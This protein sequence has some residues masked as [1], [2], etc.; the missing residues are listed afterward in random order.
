MTRIFT[1]TKALLA[2][3]LF[4][5]AGIVGANAQTTVV[6][7]FTKADAASAFGATVATGSSGYLTVNQAYHHSSDPIAF[8]PTDAEGVRFFCSNANLYT[9][10]VNNGGAFTVS[11]DKGYLITRIRAYISKY[12]KAYLWGDDLFPSNSWGGSETSVLLSNTSGVTC[13]IDS[14]AITY[15]PESTSGK[16]AAKLDFST[17]TVSVIFGETETFTEPTLTG[18]SDGAVSYASSDESVATVDENGNVTIL[19]VGTTEITATS[20]ETDDYDAGTASYTLTVWPLY[21]S[22]S[23]LKAQIVSDASS[24]AKDYY[25]KLT[26]AVV[27]YANTFAGYIE[28]G[29]TGLALYYSDHGL[30]TG[31]VLNGT[32][33][34]SALVYRGLAEITNIEAAAEQI[35]TGGTV[36]T[37]EVSIADLIANQD[38][39]D[40]RRVKI[41]SAEVTKTLS[42]SIAYVAKDGSSLKIFSSADLNNFSNVGNVVDVEGFLYYYYYHDDVWG[43]TESGLQFRV[44]EEPT[45]VEGKVSPRLSFT[46]TSYSVSVNGSFPRPVLNNPYGVEVTYSSS[47]EAVATV[48]ANTGAVTI[49]AAGTATITASSVATD[50]YRAGSA[51]YKLTV[52]DADQAYYYKKVTSQSDIVNAGSYLIVSPDKNYFLGAANSESTYRTAVSASKFCTHLTDELMLVNQNNVSGAPYEVTMW[53]T[54][55]YEGK[56]TYWLEVVTTDEST[57]GSTVGYL[58]HTSTA[59][60]ISEVAEGNFYPTMRW[61]VTF[62]EADGTVD[63]MNTVPYQYNGSEKYGYL[64]FNPTSSV[65]RFATYTGTQQAPILYRRVNVGLINVVTEEGYAT[66]YTDK[67]FRMPAGLTGTTITGV[68]ANGQLIADWAYTEGT[69]VPGGTGLLLKGEKGSYY[70]VVLDE[71]SA[72]A[73]DDN[74]LHGFT[75]AQTI[76]ADDS[77]NFYKLTYSDDDHV[78]GFYWGAQDGGPFYCSA[79]KSYLALPKTAE[80]ALANGYSFDRTVTSIADVRQSQPD[81]AVYSLTGVRLDENVE[82]LPKGFYIV[83]GKKVIVK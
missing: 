60:D 13:I 12:C 26:D 30:E 77:K 75:T 81:A 45:L 8:T 54:G 58:A 21:E 31:N 50:D 69:E 43:R 39:Y 10:R 35:T 65:R 18:E 62:N 7:D 14:M 33:K 53:S 27:S 74:L 5:I 68:D 34:V 49:V 46:T 59:N 63:I 61:A 17:S 47:N 11:A 41:S 9:L 23:A 24:T 72:T 66:F 38:L 70:Y 44:W 73:P 20:A 40:S 57:G 36:P 71:V 1:L 29:T 82:S 22:L 56:D 15:Q 32:V 80:T 42:A 76:P 3:S 28:E 37:L 2:L 52:V 4:C 16:N 25:V 83:G 78:I 19:A 51:S 55:V 64:Q 6:Y 67:N 48:D 79:Y